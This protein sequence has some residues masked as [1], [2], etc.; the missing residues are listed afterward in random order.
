MRISFKKNYKKLA[1]S[2]AP[3][4]KPST[5][6][7]SSTIECPGVCPQPVA[8]LALASF[9]SQPPT[10]THTH[11]LS[12]ASLNLIITEKGTVGLPFTTPYLHTHSLSLSLS[13]TLRQMVKQLAPYLYT[14]SL[15]SFIHTA[16]PPISD[17][18]RI[19]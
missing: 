14:H 3:A 7:L 16:Y 19:Q 15:S 11:T 13:C 4:E 6:P 5:G 1:S 12:H 10:Y 9:P 8:L 18:T 2:V 17:L